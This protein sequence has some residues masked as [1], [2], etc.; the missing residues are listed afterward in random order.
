MTKIVHLFPTFPL[1][2]NRFSNRIANTDTMFV[3]I[4][5]LVFVLSL[6]GCDDNRPQDNEV[7]KPLVIGYVTGQ[8]KSVEDENVEAEFNAVQ[9]AISDINNAGGVLGKDVVLEWRDGQN[10]KDI[11]IAMARELVEKLNVAAIIGPGRSSTTIATFKNVSD[12]NGIL[13][14]S[15]SATS[16]DISNSDPDNMSADFLDEDH[17]LFRTIVSDELLGASLAKLLEELAYKATAILYVDNEYGN[18][19]VNAL[20]DNFPEGRISAKIP[21]PENIEKMNERGKKD[22]TQYWLE[23]LKP[24]TEKDSD[25]LVLIGYGDAIVA[26][27]KTAVTH[28]LVDDF[29]FTDQD[30][31]A[32][33]LWDE[34]KKRRLWSGAM[35][36]MFGMTPAAPD[37]AAKSQFE[38]NY[39]SRYPKLQSDAGSYMGHIYDATVLIAL[40]AAYSGNTTSSSDIR[41]GLK[42]IAGPPGEPV[43]LDRDGGIARALELAEA[44]RMINYEGVA[45][46]L[47]FDENGDVT[48]P[49]MVWKIIGDDIEIE[50]YM[51]P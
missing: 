39:A 11:A 24:L 29:M 34:N 4:V 18:G 50:R 36:G 9:L 1:Y 47:D 26:S 8:L 27:V 3:R 28:G 49:V 31:V 35:H 48:A 41:D 51:T 40:A 12:P 7:Q 42:D 43:G 10:D 13:Q 21:Y 23:T 37:S 16:P 2:P 14:I 17:L 6:M 46:S 33:L 30:I 22:S 44:R 38:E 19:L 32:P 5:C 20:A 45:G 15:H 25:V